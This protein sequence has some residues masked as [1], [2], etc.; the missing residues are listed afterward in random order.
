[1]DHE[2]FA[3]AFVAQWKPSVRAALSPLPAAAVVGA[4]SS[5]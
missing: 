4:A 5:T 3:E 1:L 2:R